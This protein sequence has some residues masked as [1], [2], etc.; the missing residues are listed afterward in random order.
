MHP[1]TAAIRKSALVLVL[2]T[3]SL[4]SQHTY[5]EPACESA[6]KPVTGLPPLISTPYSHQKEQAFAELGR[7]LFFDKLLSI[8]NSIS[9]ATC[10]MPEAA[11]TQN[12]LA[13]PTGIDGRQLRRNAPTLLNVAFM[14]TLFFDGRESMLENQVWSPLLAANEMGNPSREFVLEKIR[15]NENY[16]NRFY[17]LAGDISSDTLGQ[18][19][20]AYERTLVASDSRF[21]R[22]YFDGDE[23]STRVRLGYTLFHRHGCSSCHLI[24]EKNAL[25]TDHQF[26]NTGIALKT[27]AENPTFP[28]D[29]GRYETTGNPEDH[30][31]FRTPGLRNI[32]LTSPYMHDGSLATIEEVIDYYMAGGFDDPDKSARMLPFSLSEVEKSNLAEFL[33]SL[34]SL[35]INSALHCPPAP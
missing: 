33:K 4:F 18:A 22:W 2:V 27:A 8:D 3:A 9:C 7:S 30:R 16:R 21:D 1:T 14:E 35:N 13:T 17:D 28:I 10:H 11:F 15:Q 26:H 19:I 24:G 12:N 34:T 25:F 31:K 32:T 5:P 29:Q 23:V 20:A 6:S